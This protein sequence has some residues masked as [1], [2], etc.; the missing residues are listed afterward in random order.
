MNHGTDQLIDPTMAQALH[1]D[2]SGWLNQGAGREGPTDR[3]AVGGPTDRRQS[4]HQP[5]A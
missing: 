1:A 5:V 4:V 2:A 3:A